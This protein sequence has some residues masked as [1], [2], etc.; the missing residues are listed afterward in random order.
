MPCGQNPN[1]D[2]KFQVET[3]LHT[4][5]ATHRDIAVSWTRPGIIYGPGVTNFMIP[6]FTVPPD[7]LMTEVGFQF[8]YSSDNVIRLLLKDAGWLVT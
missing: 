8:E 6:L 4:F 7:R 1:T 5:A 2:D 3:L